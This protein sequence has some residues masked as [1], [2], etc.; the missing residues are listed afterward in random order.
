MLP[1]SILHQ[2]VN[3]EYNNGYHYPFMNSKM[4]TSKHSSV[5]TLTSP[6]VTSK[7]DEVCSLQN[8]IHEKI[9]YS[10]LS[11]TQSRY[12]RRLSYVM[13]THIKLIYHKTWH[14]VIL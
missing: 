11:K 2:Y 3:I 8:P 6:S 5:S 1:K 13:K 14:F 7:N 4:L 12:V 10:Y 9:K